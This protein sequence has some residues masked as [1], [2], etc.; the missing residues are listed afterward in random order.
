[1]ATAAAAPS[2]ARAA[3][4]AISAAKGLIPPR[5]P[6]PPPPPPP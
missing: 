1:M 2:R 6:P 5:P 3:R 4:G